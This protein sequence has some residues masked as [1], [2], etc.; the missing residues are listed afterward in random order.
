M[1]RR[2]EINLNYKLNE[3]GIPPTY[4]TDGSAGLDLYYPYKQ[5]LSLASGETAEF[6]TGVS[7]EIPEGYVGL[8]VVRS[9][10]GFKYITQLSTGASVIDSDFRGSIKVKLKNSGNRSF[11]IEQGERVV[12]LVIVP[13]V[14]ANLNRVFELEETERGDGGIGST[15]K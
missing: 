15:G 14:R 9:S 4:G 12:Q 5:T 8:L 13:Y 10:L 2:K 6:D 11:N 7:V 1:L 3:V